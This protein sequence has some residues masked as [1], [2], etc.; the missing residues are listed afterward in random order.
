MFLFRLKRTMKLGIKSLWMHRLRS[1]LTALGVIFGVSSVIA[2]LAIGEG[3]SQHA[4]EQIA[5]LGSQNIIIKT[6]EPPVEQDVSSQEGTYRPGDIGAGSGKLIGENEG[7]HGG[8]YRRNKH[9]QHYPYAWHGSSHQFSNN[10]HQGSGD[11]YL[12][13]RRH[14]S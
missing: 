2:M 12:P 11:Q 13:Q 5:R 4:Q 9:R 6:V 8:Q 10:S 1:T 14:L 3:A 7:K